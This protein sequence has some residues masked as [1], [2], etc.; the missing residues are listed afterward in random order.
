MHSSVVSHSLNHTF[1]LPQDNF[2]PEMPQLEEGLSLL[3]FS[4]L[5]PFQGLPFEGTL[6]VFLINNVFIG[7]DFAVENDDVVSPSICV[8]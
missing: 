2:P 7:N 1:R 4:A 3:K 5:D 8:V 6:D